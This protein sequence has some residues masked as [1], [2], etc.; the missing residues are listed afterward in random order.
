M[1]DAPAK[2]GRDS[3]AAPSKLS[4]KP[5]ANAGGNTKSQT[6]IETAAEI[7]TATTGSVMDQNDLNKYK[8]I[9]GVIHLE[10]SLLKTSY[11]V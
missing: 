2:G 3:Q 5:G 9:P 10:R 7:T 4:T 1:G 8:F 6:K 11:K